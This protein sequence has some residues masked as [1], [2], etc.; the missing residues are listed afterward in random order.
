MMKKIFSYLLFAMMLVSCKEKEIQYQSYE[1]IKRDLEK[2]IEVNGSVEAENTVEIYI[3]VPG[4]IEKVFVKEGDIVR[5]KQKIATISSESRTVIMDMAMGKSKEEA[6]Y[7]RKQMLPTPVFAP[8]SGKVIVLRSDVGERISGSIGQISMNEIIRANIDENDLQGVEVG[9][10]VEIRFDIDSKTVL[11]GKVEKISQISKMVNNVNVYPVEVSLPEEAGRKKLPFDIKI[12]MSVTL[13]FPVHEKKDAKALPFEA[14]NGKSLTSVFILKED[15]T[16]AK[17]KLGEV[18]GDY[19]E[20]A[21]G[22]EVGD[23]V[24][25]PAFSAGQKKNRKSPLMIKK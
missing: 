4:R 2:K 20:V 21:S 10:S 16:K 17:V 7:W 9:K 25:V 3:P 24:K 1:V 5:A 14:T 15:G 19:V 11:K 13:H 6:E 22:L 23:K 8:V 12:G 18:Y